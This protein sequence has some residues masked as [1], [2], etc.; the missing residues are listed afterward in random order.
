[1]FIHKSVVHLDVCTPF[2]VAIKP[3]FH[4]CLTNIWHFG[5]HWSTCVSDAF[6]KQ[7][8]I[9]R[10][11]SIDFRL[12]VTPQE[13]I[14]W[15]E[16]RWTGSPFHGNTTTNPPIWD[17]LIQEHMIFTRIMRWGAALFRNYLLYVSY[18]WQVGDTEFLKHTEVIFAVDIHS[19]LLDHGRRKLSQLRG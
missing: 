11:C 12:D 3:P 8:E 10:P 15:Y 4:A 7:W 19:V 14:T 13:K 9:P 6:F 5:S 2:S 17:L 1:M 16:I 18:S